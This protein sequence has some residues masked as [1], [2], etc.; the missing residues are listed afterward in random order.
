MEDNLTGN[1]KIAKNTLLLYLRTFLIMIVS[2]YTSRVVLNVLGVSDYGVYT[3]VG[4]IVTMFAVIS[5]AL[6]T[7]ISRYL[8]Y[9]LGKKDSNLL[10]RTFSTSVTVQIAIAGIVFLLC[11]IFGVYFL[12]AK[13]DIPE[14]RLYAANWVLQCSLIAFVISL[15]SVPYNAT[16]ISH[17]KMNVFAYVSILETLLKLGIVY[18]L[19]FSPFDKLITYAFLYTVVILLIR[20]IYGIYCGRAFEECRGKREF[21]KPIFKEMLSFA[22]WNFFSNAVYVF[23]TQGINIIINLYYGVLLNAA[24]GVATQV[25][26]TVMQFVNNFTTAINPQITKN[27]ASGDY[28]RVHYLVEEGA[29]FSFFLLF[30][31]CLPIMI[32]TE[33]ILGLWLKEVPDYAVSFTRLTCMVSLAG[34]IGNSGYTACLAAG[35]IKKYTIVVSILMSSVFLLTWIA[36]SVGGA[37]E[38]AYYVYFIMNINLLFVRLYF[39]KTMIGLKPMAFVKNVLVRVIAVSFVSLLMPY[40]ITQYCEASI[41]RL[42]INTI[43]CLFSA[44]ISILFVGLNDK[45]RVSILKFIKIKIYGKLLFK[46]A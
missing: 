35:Q 39:L 44:C 16:I 22:G 28:N 30:L 26:S 45:E 18:C 13:L 42:I 36:Y 41:L 46:R 20:I 29:K 8:T 3:V 33:T 11:E 27:Y 24:R 12:N 14:G 23:N 34:A 5:G 40:V 38:Y 6:T 31:V 4:G 1:K 37:A 9:A 10:K 25:E 19:L 7:A 21:D 2:L 32:E 17:E 43:V 15:L